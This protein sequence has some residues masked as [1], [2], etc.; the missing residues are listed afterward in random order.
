MAIP[1][2]V[3]TITLHC[4][5]NRRGDVMLTMGASPSPDAWH[6]WQLLTQKMGR[7]KV[8]FII[9]LPTQCRITVVRSVINE[10]DETGASTFLI[11]RPA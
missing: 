11:E 4:L 3:P 9:K 7:A 2:I 8:P 6:F 1:A 5:A 10:A